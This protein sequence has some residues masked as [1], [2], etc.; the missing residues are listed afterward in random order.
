MFE[1]HQYFR[2]GPVLD[3]FSARYIEKNGLIYTD[4]SDEPLNALP[5]SKP[6]VYTT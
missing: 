3:Q 6:V 5:F 4:S 1:I 2:F